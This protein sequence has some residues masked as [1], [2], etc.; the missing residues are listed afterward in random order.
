[1]TPPCA[2]QM[3]PTVPMVISV[4][5]DDAAVHEKSIPLGTARVGPAVPDMCGRPRFRAC[6][7]SVV[8]LFFPADALPAFVGQPWDHQKGCHRVRPPPAAERVRE[9]P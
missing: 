6:R 3:H 4:R 8:A 9:K 5:A 7:P 2:A 1:M